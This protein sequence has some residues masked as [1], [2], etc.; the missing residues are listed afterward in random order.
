[1]ATLEA[2]TSVGDVMTASAIA[3]KTVRLSSST[4]IW[5]GDTDTPTNAVFSG[6]GQNLSGNMTL[7]VYGY[8]SNN[9]ETLL[10]TTVGNSDNVSKTHTISSLESSSYVRVEADISTTTA[11]GSVSDSITI[12]RLVD[13]TDGQSAYSVILSNESHTVAAS[14]DRSVQDFTGSGTTITAYYGTSQLNFVTTSTP[15]SGEFT[16]GTITFAGGVDDGG[17]TDNGSTAS[18]E[19][20]DSWTGTTDVASRTLPIVLRGASTASSTSFSKIQT[21]T[22]SLTGSQGATGAAGADGAAGATGAAGA[23][24]ERGPGRFFLKVTV[25]DNTAPELGPSPYETDTDLRDN[26]AAAIVASLGTGV[27]PIKNDMVTIQYDL[28]AAPSTTLAT[29]ISSGS[30]VTSLTVS[31]NGTTGFPDKGRVLIGTGST[32]DLFTYTSRTT[33]TLV[34]SSQNMVNAHSTTTTVA[35]NTDVVIRNAI[36]D[37]VSTTAVASWDKFELQI[38]GS[39]LVNGTVVSDSIATGAI[40]AS[41]ILVDGSIRITD[42]LGNISGGL[43]DVS[44]DNTDNNSTISDLLSDNDNDGASSLGDIGDGFWVGNTAQGGRMFVGKAQSGS[45]PSYMKWTG[46]KLLITNASLVDAAGVAITSGSGTSSATVYAYQRVSSGSSAP[47]AKPSTTLFYDFTNGLWYTSIAGSTLSTNLG[48]SWTTVI[49]SGSGDL[50]VAQTNVASKADRIS[51]VSADWGD[52]LEFAAVGDG[53]FNSAPVYAYKKITA[54][55]SI[56]TDKPTSVRFYEFSTGDWYAAATGGSAL[57]T[58]IGNSWFTYIPSGSGDLYVVQ[59][60]ASS[61]NARDSIAVGDWGAIK[62]LTSDGSDGATGAAGS[63]GSDGTDGTNGSDGAT[64]ATGAAGADAASWHT[65]ATYSVGDVVS[66]GTGTNAKLYICISSTTTSTANPTSATGNWN[67][68]VGIISASAGLAQTASI[69]VNAVTIP[70]S[71]YTSGSIQLSG[72]AGGVVT[73]QSLSITSTGAPISITYAASLVG[74]QTYTSIIPY[75]HNAYFYAVGWRFYGHVT[76]YRGSTELS[77]YTNM[78]ADFSLN[79]IDTPGAGTFTYYMKVESVNWLNSFTPYY[80]NKRFLGLLEVK[81]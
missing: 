5:N 4:Q 34:G 55:T 31:S 47:T 76:L 6:S 25:S 36:H 22:R 63:D 45:D 59:T 62:A 40:N 9:T 20:L 18:L 44:W 41:K 28:N 78:N 53:G 49:P 11:D 61:A 71:A 54:G 1:M 12:L 51:V 32:Q 46:D 16:I 24:G 17:I 13:G 50:Y 72:T 74:S 81:R 29:A 33:S 23:Q 80:A 19:N 75:P 27:T 42:D 66:Y 65:D 26:A 15:S 37:G 39:L 21:L 67:E 79:Y 60:T 8:T 14:S 58:T 7:K 57:T 30:A 70:V 38:D 52:I 77:E 35:L 69:A 48:N 10:S 3:A 73:I 2:I 56:G 68:Y 64:G 43:T